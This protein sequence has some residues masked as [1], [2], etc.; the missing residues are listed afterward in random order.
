[1]PIALAYT[2]RISFDAL[3]FLKK[4]MDIDSIAVLDDLDLSVYLS[5]FNACKQYKFEKDGSWFF[6]IGH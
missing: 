3:S 4:D 6:N 2:V 1:V 5:E